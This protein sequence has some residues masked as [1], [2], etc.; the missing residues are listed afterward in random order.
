MFKLMSFVICL[1]ILSACTPPPIVE[2]EVVSSREVRPGVT[3]HL[4]QTDSPQIPYYI[5]R[6]NK[7]DLQKGARVTLEIQVNA[8][9]NIT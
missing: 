4:I 3:E 8:M 2:G 1:V 6:T 7:N 5:L 9:G